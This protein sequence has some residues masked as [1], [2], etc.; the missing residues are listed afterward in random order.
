[1]A[2]DNPI[3]VGHP[4]E[5]WATPISPRLLRRGAAA[6]DPLHARASWFV[7]ECARALC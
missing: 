5:S 3:H 2:W 6:A 4:S 1:M 7:C